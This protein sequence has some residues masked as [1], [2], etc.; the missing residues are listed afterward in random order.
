MKRFIR[1]MLI[2]FLGAGLSAC[3]HTW[4]EEVQLSD[5]RVIVIERDQIN[6][7]GGDE[8][9]LNRS[10]TKP[11]E[12]RI[13]FEYPIGS[14]KMIEWRSVKTDDGMWPE[15]PLIF[16]VYSGQPTIFTLVAVSI[17]CEIY[18]KYVYKNGAWVEER[19]PEHFEQHT[20]NL[21]FGNRRDM[22]SFLNLEE[23][24][25]RNSGSGYR[26]SLKQVGPSLKVTFP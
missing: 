3:T 12:Y 17:C 8:W 20:T 2:L 5:G 1:L 21:F 22:P 14:G 7:G 11:K 18:S 15:V 24:A 16:D 13:R 25:R 9:A 19:L 6:E 10:G 23:K 26:Q 4:K